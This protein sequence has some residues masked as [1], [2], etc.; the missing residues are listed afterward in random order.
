MTWRLTVWTAGLLILTG[1]GAHAQAAGPQLPPSRAP[2]ESAAPHATFLGRYCLACHNERLLARGTVPV[3]FEELTV[4]DV[5]AG[6]EVW[7]KVVRKLHARAM[8]PAGRPRPDEETYDGFV[9]WLETELDRAAAARPNPG[10][11]AVRRL[12]SAE[13]INAIRDL[14]ALEVD[15]EWLLFPADDVDEQGF[16][17]N[18][19]VLSVSPALFERYLV[20]ANRISRLAVGD[21]TIGPGFAPA[22][23]STPRLLYQDDR[24]SEDLPFGS[25]GGMAIRYHF[26]LDGQYEV[27]I[28][29]RRQIY[30]YIIGM[31][32]P[33][34]LDVRLDGALVERFTIG[35]A[36]RKGY[37][38]AYT[39]FG[40]IRGDPEWEDY[41]SGGADAGLVVRFP[42]QAGTRVLGVTFANVRSEPTGI[43]ERRLS[44]FSLS[45]EGFYLRQRGG[46]ARGSDRP[47]RRD[48]PR[49][50]AEPA[51]DLHVPPGERNADD[52]PCARQI[53]SALARRAYRRPVTE[54]EVTRLLTF[55]TSNRDEHGFEGGMQKALERLLVAPDFPVPGRG[56]PGGHRGRNGLSP[57]RPGAGLPVVVLPVEQHSRR[58]AARR[59]RGGPSPRADRARAAGA[60]HAGR[61][62]AR[63]RSSTTSRV[64]G[65]NWTAWAAC[66]RTSRCSSN[67]TRTSGRTWSR[68]R[69]CSCG[70]SFAKTAA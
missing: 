59:G 29:L 51:A 52:E 28:R 19:D 46:R 40:T 39:F 43:L 32:K 27:R 11:P 50:H 1:T 68:K 10:R 67:S 62:C 64:S 35:D 9:T 13:Y 23:Y 16:S 54:D 18:A 55:Y 41:L 14:L 3:S 15:E 31:G 56:R 65:C 25:R 45:G 42:A 61:R 70:A 57:Q 47:V 2:A 36:D 7:E 22:S 33:Q 8:P 58:R 44:G 4:A 30:D 21:P 63:R 66:S 49:R 69:S 17:T 24:M 12:T 60:A 53:L 5:G 34:Q 20:A 37:P 38:S 26:P 48:G 6:A